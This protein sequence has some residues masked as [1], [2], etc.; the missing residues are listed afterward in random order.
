MSIRRRTIARSV[1]S[2]LLW[3]AAIITAYY[4]LPLEGGA[5]SSVAL[6]VVLALVLVVG[7]SVAA[8]PSVRNHR[9]P[10]LRAVQLL[11]VVVALAIVAFASVYLLMSSNRPMAFS[12]PLGHTDAL[13]FSL[14]TASTVGYGDIHAKSEAARIVV[15]IHMVTNVAV[16]GVVAR[17][18]AHAARQRVEE[19]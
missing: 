7:V 5:V 19:R 6:R 3:V 15:M 1:A 10:V 2:S 16:I 9:F 8:V 14:T 4:V 13:Y 12:E 11:A 18:I 17:V